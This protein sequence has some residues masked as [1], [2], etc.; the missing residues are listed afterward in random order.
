MNK[1]NDN[2]NIVKNEKQEIEGEKNTHCK[3]Y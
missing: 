2:D 3:A 1:K